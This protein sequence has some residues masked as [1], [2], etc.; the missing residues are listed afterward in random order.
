MADADCFA[1][2]Q[3]FVVAIAFTV[4]IISAVS[5]P[6]PIPIPVSAAGTTGG[7]RQAGRC[8]I[9]GDQFNITFYQ[10][11]FTAGIA[12]SFAISVFLGGT[13]FVDLN[14]IATCVLGHI[15]RLVGR[16]D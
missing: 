14:I 2:E 16:G 9:I 6:V 13:V 15:E 11:I 10:L 7:F 5:I 12:E 1:N 8:W 4:W 3:A